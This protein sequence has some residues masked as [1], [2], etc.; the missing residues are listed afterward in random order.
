MVIEPAKFLPG[1]ALS[2]S[3]LR[4]AHSIA[5]DRTRP[6][7]ER[8]RARMILRRKT[9]RLRGQGVTDPNNVAL[10][11]LDSLGVRRPRRGR[12]T[13][14]RLG[15][16]ERLQARAPRKQLDTLDQFLET[17]GKD[18]S[19]VTE[20][21]VDAFASAARCRSTNIKRRSDLR[22]AFKIL[23]SLGLADRNPAPFVGRRGK[24]ELLLPLEGQRFESFLKACGFL[25]SSRKS[26][27]DA[28]L[29]IVR[30][31]KL[32]QLDLASL[33]EALW[34]DPDMRLLEKLVCWWARPREKD[35]RPRSKTCIQR[36]DT[37]LH[38]LW[39]WA[40]RDPVDARDKLRRLW[41]RFRSSGADQGDLDKL[42][43]APED[44]APAPRRERCEAL[45]AWYAEEIARCRESSASHAALV[46][47]LRE[48]DAFFCWT[49]NGARRRSF[50]GFRF[51]Q[52][53]QNERGQWYFDE[54]PTKKTRQ[55]R[56]V[57]NKIWK[58][59]EQWFSRWYVPPWLIALF[60]E[61]LKAE[62]PRYD[63]LEYL[64]TRRRELVPWEPAR[65]D[66]FGA[67]MKGK[68][69]A[70]MWRGRR[71]HLTISGV[72]DLGVKI[73]RVRLGAQRGGPH[74]LRR[75]A[76]LNKNALAKLYP[77]AAEALQHLTA[78]TRA[79]YEWSEDN[80]VGLM[81]EVGGRPAPTP[82]PTSLPNRA[83]PVSRRPYQTRRSPRPA[84][85]L[86][87]L[88]R[89]R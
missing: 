66:T 59:G 76:I 55:P 83:A 54:V 39:R 26:S 27:L 77:Q 34:S 8:R 2:E 16:S 87:E 89:G 28:Y 9:E 33:P 48:R 88:R 67:H 80:D 37:T 30:W 63:L 57:V 85:T 68:P 14:A 78:K 69:V 13:L 81:W 52:L 4:E 56:R 12:P 29:A 49:E 62:D 44:P 17:V 60:A 45:P 46:S 31:T 21:D 40:G 79:I 10:H 38:R 20:A 25:P 11:L 73:V 71:G 19:A 82:E 58:I 24:R 51:D 1:R 53:K 75:R 70:P 23:I 6:R 84:P 7:E 72:Y 32:E 36:L 50:A 18:V 35:G 3:E 41:R 42:D 22:S 74:A 86:E 15:L 64:R 47:I 65:D 5:A 43:L 61:T